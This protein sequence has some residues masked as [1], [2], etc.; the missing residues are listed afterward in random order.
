MD[1]ASIILLV[2]GN[3]VAIVVITRWVPV[4][5]ERR[6][7]WFVIHAA[8]MSAVIAGWAIRR[9]PAMSLNIV[10]LAVSTAW[11]Y[12]GGRALRRV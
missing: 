2:V 7:T 3:I 4:V 1:I 10:W 11:Y 9:P 6:T 8:A 12:L 5:R